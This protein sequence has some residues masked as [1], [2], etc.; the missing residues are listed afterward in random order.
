MNDTNHLDAVNGDRVDDDCDDQ[1]ALVNLMR[2]AMWL[3][4]VILNMG[5]Y[6]RS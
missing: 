3:G 4:D 2:W 1:L 5:T 6:L